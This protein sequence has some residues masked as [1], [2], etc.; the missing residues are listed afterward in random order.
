MLNRFII[1]IIFMSLDVVSG[2]GRDILR[3]V[4]ITS[5]KMHK[6]LIKKGLSLIIWL[7]AYI[8]TEQSLAISET[9][10]PAEGVVFIYLISTEVMSIV[11]NC[12]GFKKLK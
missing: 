3:S 11:E 4:K 12:G 5:E 1:I 6:G 9:Y 8:V 2:I 7:T 10:I